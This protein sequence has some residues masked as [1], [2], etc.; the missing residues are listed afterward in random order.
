MHSPQ[1]SL[2]DAVQTHWIAGRSLPAEASETL[3]VTNPASGECLTT[4]PLA[5]QAEADL[6]VNSARDA[7]DAWGST[8]PSHRFALLTE[9]ADRIKGHAMELATLLVMENGKPLHQAQGEVSAAIA[10]LRQVASLAVHLRSGAQQSGAGQ[11]NYQNRK[12]RGVA[13]C[14]V[15][16]NFPVALALEN[17]GAN[18]AVGNT[19]VLKPSEKTP[20][21]T[22]RLI[23]IGFGELPEGVCNVLLGDGDAGRALVADS[24]VD[25]V[26]F[27]G[28]VAVGREISHVAGERWAKLILELGGNDPFIVDDTV[29]IGRA[30]DFAVRAKYTNAGQICTTPERFFVQRGVFDQF[31][32]RFVE[33]SNR[34]HLGDGLDVGV[35]MGPLIDERHRDKVHRTV[36]DAV[37]GGAQLLCGGAPVPGAGA[38]YPATVLTNVA[39]D[40]D[41][42]RDETFGP[43]SPV[44]RYEDFDEALQQANDSRFGLASIVCTTDARRAVRAQ[45]VL[46]AGMVKINTMRGKAPGAT[47]EPFGD[48]GIGHGYGNELLQ[49]LTRQQSVHWQAEL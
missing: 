33:A 32:E 9:A 28:S 3:E 47:S 44:A 48:S 36:Q 2:P 23:E 31:V 27:V 42:L 30:V 18:L 20:L 15:P 5:G 13:A 21:A 19:V 1:T 34:L 35:D 4:I 39:A 17:V 26:V 6:A 45:E 22:R 46:R 29:D 43:V 10:N 41:L 40:A 8:S 16:W 12:P 37:V 49:E 11:L 25:V 38:F 14:I 7:R 24:R